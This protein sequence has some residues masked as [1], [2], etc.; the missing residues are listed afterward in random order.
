MLVRFRHML[1]C[2]GMGIKAESFIFHFFCSY[3]IFGVPLPY[4]HYE[5]LHCRLYIRRIHTRLKKHSFETKKDEKNI[6]SH[7]K[8]QTRRSGPYGNI[9]QSRID[10]K[11][12]VESSHETILDS[13]SSFISLIDSFSCLILSLTCRNS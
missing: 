4:T 8:T 9:A 1:F 13:M 5:G 7:E 3:A 10:E 11:Q 6:K 12:F 2:G